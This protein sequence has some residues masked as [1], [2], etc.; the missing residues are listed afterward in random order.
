MVTAGQ[1]QALTPDDDDTTPT[2]RETGSSQPVAVQPAAAIKKS[3][4]D[5]QHGELDWYRELRESSATFIL[6]FG[7]MGEDTDNGKD[8]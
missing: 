2:T 3:R 7:T 8:I 4:N 5:Y 1:R 6:H